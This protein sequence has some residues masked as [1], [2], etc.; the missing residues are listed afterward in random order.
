[1]KRVTVLKGHQGSTYPGYRGS[2]GYVENLSCYS[3][4][5]RPNSRQDLAVLVNEWL[6]FDIERHVSWDEHY[7]LKPFLYSMMI[8]GY[9]PISFWPW[10]RKKSHPTREEFAKIASQLSGFI[11]DEEFSSRI[12]EPQYI[13]PEKNI[14]INWSNISS[15]AP[16]MG[17][18]RICLGI[19]QK[20]PI[21]DLY[22]VTSEI[23]PYAVRLFNQL[24]PSRKLDQNI[25][26][27]SIRIAHES[28]KI[29]PKCRV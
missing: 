29:L 6:A 14:F 27:E 19:I 1:M 21:P 11:I 25:V 13:N 15:S 4:D 18:D 3:E 9:Y 5:A 8:D 12:G 2:S 17:R 24:S 28:N 7:N 20:E 22:V 16:K 26:E 23:V 10:F